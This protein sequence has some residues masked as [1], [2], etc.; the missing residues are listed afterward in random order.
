MDLTALPKR[1]TALRRHRKLSKAALARAA[2]IYRGVLIEIEGGGSATVYLGAVVALALALGVRPSTLLRGWTGTIPAA[3]SFDPPMN[4][5]VFDVEWRRRLRAERK[6]RGLGAKAA[7]SFA[8]VQ[9]PWLVR[10]ETGVFARVNLDSLV[11]LCNGLEID[12]IKDIIV[13]AETA[14]LEDRHG[15]QHQDEGHPVVG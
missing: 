2:G 11:K 1:L 15:H 14:A 5:E 6:R 9:Q 4:L 8:G 12:L 3:G 10:V 7:A 13:P